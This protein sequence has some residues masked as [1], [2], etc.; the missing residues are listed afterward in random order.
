MISRALALAPF[1]ASAAGQLG[2]GGLFGGGATPTASTGG[3]GGLIGSIADPILNPLADGWTF[4]GCYGDVN[5]DELGGVL[6]SAPLGQ[7]MDATVC[8]TI[9][10]TVDILLPANYAVIYNTDFCLCPSTI[11]RTLDQNNC[12]TPCGGLLLGSSGE[13]C[14]APGKAVV[15]GRG[16]GTNLLPVASS[17]PIDGFVPPVNSGV[18]PPLESGVGAPVRSGFGPPVISGFVP[19]V[20][21]GVGPPLESGVGAPVN[22]GVGP[23]VNSGVA[24]PL[25]SGVGPPVNS[26]IALP[27]ESGVVPP[28]GAT[29]PSDGTLPGLPGAGTT[30]IEPVITPPVGGGTLPGLPGGGTLPGLP[31]GGTLPGL[32][33]GGT[34]PGLPG[35][36]TLPGLPGGTIPELSGAA[37][38]PSGAAGGGT[39]GLIGNT[40]DPILDPLAGGWTFQGCY[41]DVNVDGLGS[42][43]QTAPLGQT[44]DATVCQ[45]I[46]NT[47]NIL[48]PV[49]Y[50]VIYDT[51][52]CLCPAT[53]TQT[54]VQNDC[55]TP[56]GGLLL[57]SQG[58]QC[59]APG[60]AV[61]YHRGSDQ[62]LKTIVK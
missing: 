26:G 46:C 20:N 29:T 62:L 1:V 22:S 12:F 27:V 44:M 18:G 35:G 43:L 21:S 39:G 32:P 54:L 10:N 58:Q 11:T 5:T 60:K 28:G 16:S 40:L 56:C 13:S 55:F 41:S 45:T 6:R 3:G 52:F 50:A 9:C 42:L 7:V 31:G 49:N 34:L 19:P 30:P 24:P 33:G 25:E 37:P 17:T 2:L 61:V 14:G 51:D 47:A 57:G 23:P 15:W 53:V 4:R 48:L 36:G 8:E 59:G 38:A